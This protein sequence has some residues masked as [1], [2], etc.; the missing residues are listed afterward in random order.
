[1]L[2][3]GVSSYLPG[4]RKKASIVTEVHRVSERK[5]PPPF[6]C[7]LVT[8]TNLE[9]IWAL[10]AIVERWQ[11]KIAVT[12]LF[13]LNTSRETVARTTGHFPTR[14]TV[15]NVIHKGGEYPINILRNMAVKLVNTSHYLVIDVDLVP[16]VGLEQLILHEDMG[17]WLVHPRMALVVPVFEFSSDVRCPD[18]SSECVSLLPAS[19]Q[20]LSACMEQQ[21]C[22]VHHQIF[23]NTSHSTTDHKHW[24]SPN[25]K[26]GTY[27]ILCFDSIRYEPYVVLPHLPDTPKYNDRFVGHG[28]NKIQFITHLRYVGFNF[29][30]LARGFLFHQAHQ[31][32]AGKVAWL[33]IDSGLNK[34][35]TQLFQDFKVSLERKYLAPSVPLCVNRVRTAKEEGDE[36]IFV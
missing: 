33:D 35:M 6:S 15:L 10:S 36:P 31:M 8:Q 30:V 22:Q 29:R 13:P 14:V 5:K 28:Q 18:T 21:R 7:T 27:P 2:V 23:S 32:S 9:R 4:L 3:Y 17:Q 34:R 20:E 26:K 1:V 19:F 24:L 25:L 12:V 11:G 16:S